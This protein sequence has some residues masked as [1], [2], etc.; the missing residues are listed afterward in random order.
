MVWPSEE[1]DETRKNHLQT[2][3]AHGWVTSMSLEGNPMALDH[4]L[5]HSLIF[6]YW[7]RLQHETVNPLWKEAF[8]HARNHSQFFYVLNNDDTIRMHSTSNTSSQQP[9]KNARSSIKKQLKKDYFRNWLK[10]RNNTSEC[11]REKF[12]HKEVKYELPIGRLSQN[13]QKPST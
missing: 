12:T 9:V 11:S 8:H 1:S 6:S 2:L 3:F 13:Y 10:A 5:T 4:S 7:L